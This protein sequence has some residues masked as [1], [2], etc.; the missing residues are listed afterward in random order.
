VLT[1]LH[2]LQVMRAQDGTSRGSGF[3]AFGS[4]E[5]ATKA[6]RC[7]SIIVLYIPYFRLHV[8]GVFVH[9]FIMTALVKCLL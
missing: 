7:N 6:V 4:P 2:F 5:E 8:A 3:V 9:I 1:S